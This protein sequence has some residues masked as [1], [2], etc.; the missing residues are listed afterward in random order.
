AASS[1]AAAHL[2]QFAGVG[3]EF[4]RQF[5][6]PQNLAAMMPDIYRSPVN[7]VIDRINRAEELKTSVDIEQLHKSSDDEAELKWQE[8][9]RSAGQLPLV[10]RLWR[11]VRNVHRYPE[12]LRR[13]LP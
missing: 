12:Y 8:A 1:R 4:C 3:E 9:R 7:P 10:P 2:S 6:S 11:A 13:I 5:N